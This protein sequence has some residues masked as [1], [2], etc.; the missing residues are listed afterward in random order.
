MDVFGMR[1]FDGHAQ[2]VYGFDNEYWNDELRDYHLFI[3]TRC[4]EQEAVQ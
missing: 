3:T 4:L 2:V 1:E